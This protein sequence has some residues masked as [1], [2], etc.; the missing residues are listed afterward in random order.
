L[1]LTSGGGDVDIDAGS[2]TITLS[3]TTRLTMDFGATTL[4]WEGVYSS[5]PPATT[6]WGYIKVVT[7]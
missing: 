7:A 2:G 6:V 5:A 1:T 3:Y 4:S